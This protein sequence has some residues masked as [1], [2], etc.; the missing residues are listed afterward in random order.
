MKR[1]TVNEGVIIGGAGQLHAQVLAVGARARASQEVAPGA[2]AAAEVQA[3]LAALRALIEEQCERLP[4]AAGL[5]AAVASVAAELE[6]ERPSKL[7]I[8]SILE[9]IARGAEQVTGIA[10]AALGL[11]A[12]IVGLIA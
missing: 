12:L 2:D 8:T 3:Q 4:D 5:K 1:A 11:K 10:K 6:R 9:A 7:A